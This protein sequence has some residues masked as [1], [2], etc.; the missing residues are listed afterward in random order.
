MVNLTLYLGIVA[1]LDEE[2]LESVDDEDHKLD[3]LELGQVPL[4][5]QV[6]LDT[7]PQGGQ[8]VI[9]VHHHVDAR[10]EKT[11]ECCMTSSDKLKYFVYFES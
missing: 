9:R 2:R 5:P 7:W 3:H 10:V 11:T 1:V 4:P 8:E 6:G